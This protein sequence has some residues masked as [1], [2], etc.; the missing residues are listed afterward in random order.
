MIINVCFFGM[1]SSLVLF[2]NHYNIGETSK[3]LY[4]FEYQTK[5]ERKRSH[6]VLYQF[7]V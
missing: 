3:P 1:L 6:L 2:F 7:V 5:R 4:S